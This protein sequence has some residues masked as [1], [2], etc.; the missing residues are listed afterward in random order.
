MIT[1]PNITY[2]VHL[3]SQFMHKPTTSHMQAAKRVLRYLLSCPGQGILLATSSTASL[4]AYCDS[5]WAGCPMTR[6]STTGFC[7]FLGS[8]PISW[9]SKK[10]QVV[11]RSTAEAEYRAMAMTTCEVTWI[12]QLL[13]DLGIKRLKSTILKC[14]NKAALAI[15]A[16]PVQHEKTKHVEID[17]HFVREKVADGTIKPQYVPTMHQV[18]DILTKPL[19]I[20]KHMDLLSKLGVSPTTPG[21]RGSVEI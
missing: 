15:A 20:V 16:N 21:L 19:P 6:R 5:D 1:R 9:K 11:A 10:Q 7:I 12:T 18:A 2:V 3:L 14:D 17:C 4:T 13:K 8:S